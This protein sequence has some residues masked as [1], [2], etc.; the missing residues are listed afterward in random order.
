MADSVCQIPPCIFQRPYAELEVKL[1]VFFQS[2]GLLL[3]GGEARMVQG[4][5]HCARPIPGGVD[6]CLVEDVA[7]VFQFRAVEGFLGR[8]KVLAQ[9]LEAAALLAV[10]PFLQIACCVVALQ[11][12]AVAVL[13]KQLCKAFVVLS[14]FAR[15]S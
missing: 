15:R 3:E 1:A 5:F 7:E 14:S 11:D 9:L 4:V 2:L 8:A 13:L 10:V 6:N 12:M